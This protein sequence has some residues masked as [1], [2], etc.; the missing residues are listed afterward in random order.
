VLIADPAL[1][2]SS[3]GGSKLLEKALRGGHRIVYGSVP[4]GAKH[5]TSV[6]LRN[7]EPYLLERTL[8]DAGFA[9]ERAR[10]VARK[11]NGNL[12]ALVRSLKDVPPTPSWANGPRAADL[13]IAMLLGGWNE[14]FPAD[15]KVVEKL[16]RRSYND[17]V[18]TLREV[19]ARSDAPVTHQDGVWKFVSLSEGWDALGGLIYDSHLGDFFEAAEAVLGE[20]DPALGL[21]KERRAV[22]GLLGQRFTHSATL[23]GGVA[24]TLALLGARPGSLTSCAIG[25]SASVASRVVKSVLKEATSKRWASVNELL[26][27]AR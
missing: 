20:D 24:T 26:A 17:W 3:E 12:G 16:S 23:R 10:T 21:T 25:L 15:I 14:S 4:G 2:V 6:P 13:M 11:C 1:D 7:P 19:A 9:D 27:V 18:T 5:S 22:A 8:R